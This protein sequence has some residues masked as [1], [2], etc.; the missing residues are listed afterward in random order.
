M[1]QSHWRQQEGLRAKGDRIVLGADESDI[2]QMAIGRRVN[3]HKKDNVL[4]MNIKVMSL[5]D[6]G[7]GGGELGFTRQ[8]D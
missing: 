7:A 6:H 5:G 3:L 1:S 8:D 4:S 2:S